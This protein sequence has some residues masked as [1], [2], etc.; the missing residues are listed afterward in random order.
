[1]Q[2]LFHIG[3]GCSHPPLRGL[4][5]YLNPALISPFTD[6]IA[7]F[8]CN[9]LFDMYVPPLASLLLLWEKGIC[10]EML[11]CSRTCSLDP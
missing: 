8:H 10:H 9:K 1:M 2:A 3:V 11:E 5:Y 7:S 6:L 4:E